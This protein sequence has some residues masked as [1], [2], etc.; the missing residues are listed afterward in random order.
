[1]KGATKQQYLIG[2]TFKNRSSAGVNCQL[3]SKATEAIQLIISSCSSNHNS[4]SKRTNTILIRVISAE[5]NASL[6]ASSLYSLFLNFKIC[7]TS[8]KFI[9]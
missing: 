6:S 7:F 3:R 4:F 5:Q 2:K 9:S 8:D 1:M